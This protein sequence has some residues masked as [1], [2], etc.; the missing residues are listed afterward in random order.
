VEPIDLKRVMPAPAP[1]YLARERGF[2][3]L[4]AEE[5][6]T[7]WESPAPAVAFQL[8][9]YY[10]HYAHDCFALLGFYAY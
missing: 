2:A 1:S 3:F 6:S 5:S 4:R 7:Y 8:A 10:V 9:T